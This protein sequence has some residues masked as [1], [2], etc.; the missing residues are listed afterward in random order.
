[1]PLITWLAQLIFGINSSTS[2]A[3]NLR[4]NGAAT[5]EPST[6]L[7]VCTGLSEV[8]DLRDVGLA[9]QYAALMVVAQC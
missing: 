8:K 5:T 2:D 9:R 1:M 4:E 6:T 7:S 3:Y